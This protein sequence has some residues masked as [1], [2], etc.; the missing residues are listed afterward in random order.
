MALQ[1]GAQAIEAVA[2]PA[3]GL[4]HS[5]GAGHGGLQLAL[6]IALARQMAPH[7]QTIEVVGV[8]ALLGQRFI[9]A[10]GWWSALAATDQP[11]FA[12]LQLRLQ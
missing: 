8:K 11:G 10:C 7:L 1:L 5:G 9:E 4:R 2:P 12:V 6:A 3:I